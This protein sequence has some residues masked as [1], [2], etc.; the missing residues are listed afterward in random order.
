MCLLL[1]YEICSV[2]NNYGT[3]LLMPR[4]G[5]VINKIS[6]RMSSGHEARNFI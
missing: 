5:A 1:R 4:F 3:E 2:V 6:C